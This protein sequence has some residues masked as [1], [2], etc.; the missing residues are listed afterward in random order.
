MFWV[1]LDIIISRTS[2]KQGMERQAMHD[3]AHVWEFKKSDPIEIRSTIVIA[4]V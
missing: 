4:R 3:L 1:K 2:N